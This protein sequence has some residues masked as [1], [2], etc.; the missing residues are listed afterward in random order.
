MTRP[1]GLFWFST[2]SFLSPRPKS[3][4]WGAWTSAASDGFP[5]VVRSGSGGDRGSSSD[6]DVDAPSTKSRTWPKAA[7]REA[8]AADDGNG[9]GEDVARGGASVQDFGDGGVNKSSP[10]SPAE[11]GAT[12]PFGRGGLANSILGSGAWK[13]AYAAAANVTAAATAKA[14]NSDF[15]A[16]ATAVAAT[17]GTGGG[18]GARWATSSR[19][20]GGGGGGE[21][22]VQEGAERGEAGRGDEEKNTTEEEGE[23]PP[24]LCISVGDVSCFLPDVQWSVQMH[25]KRFLKVGDSGSVK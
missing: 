6:V 10:A 13:K 1:R 5:D 20:G 24:F 17:V 7:D 11:A 16:T 23:A 8:G 12:G 9:P 18:G 19:G 4:L 15:A 14:V 21:R 2:F 3:V 22:V 25:Q